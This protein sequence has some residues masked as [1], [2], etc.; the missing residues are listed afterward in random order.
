MKQKKRPRQQEYERTH[1]IPIRVIKPLSSQFQASRSI[2]YAMNEV[3]KELEKVEREI[4]K[5]IKEKELAEK[6]ETQY[7]INILI[8]TVILILA[9]VGLYYLITLI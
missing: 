5:D 7:A 6:I 1:I 4:E 2:L 9:G 8:H 3:E